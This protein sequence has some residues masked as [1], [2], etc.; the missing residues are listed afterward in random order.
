MAHWDREVRSLLRPTEHLRLILVGTASLNHPRIRFPKTKEPPPVI[1]AVVGHTSMNHAAESGRSMFY[2]SKTILCA[3][4]LAKSVLIYREPDR[5]TGSATVHGYLM[6]QHIFPI[7]GG[8]SLSISQLSVL[9]P[10]GPGI[11]SI[12][13]LPS[14]PDSP[15]PTVRSRTKLMSCPDSGF[16]VRLMEGENIFTIVTYDMDRLSSV[17]LACRKLRDLACM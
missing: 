1:L 14:T 12:S 15:W 16:S 6:L 17:A 2:T 4:L 7:H 11:S 13:E 3:E 8:F 10:A 5:N 9:P